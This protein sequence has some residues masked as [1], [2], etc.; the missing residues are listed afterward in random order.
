VRT[1]IWA[2]GFTLDFSWLKADVFDAQGRPRHDRG[3]SVVPGLY[4]LGLPFLSCR[5]SSF[6]W[7]VWPDAQYLAGHIADEGRTAVA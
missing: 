1:I 5:G 2:T 7:G 3:V 6:I 4:F